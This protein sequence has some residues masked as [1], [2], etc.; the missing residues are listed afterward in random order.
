MLGALV[1]LIR[2]KRSLWFDFTCQWM[3]DQ[4]RLS[5]RMEAR[6]IAED[7]SQMIQSK[8][9]SLSEVL[10]IGWFAPAKVQR[11]YQW[12][13]SHIEKL[14]NDL[15]SAFQR[16]GS[17]PGEE[18]S[19]D[20]IVDGDVSTDV[21]DA[22]TPED[23]T[24]GQRI[25]IGRVSEPVRQIPDAY[26][27]GSLILFSLRSSRNF[28]VYDGLQRLTSI[29]ILLSLLRDTWAGITP[30]D[31]QTI[32]KLLF[33]PQKTDDNGR[34]LAFPTSGQ[35]LASVVSKRTLQNRDL[36]DG[37]YRM[38]DAVTFYSNQFDRRWND[39]RRRAFLAFLQDNV[40]LT[41]TETDNHSVAYQMF[42]AANT[43]GLRL[44]V[45]DVLKGM[46]ADQVR[47]SGGTDAQVDACSKGWRDGQQRLR[48]GFNDFVHAVEVFTFRPDSRPLSG[49]RRPEKQH[50]TGEKLQAFFDDTKS[51]ATICDWV[52]GGCAAMIRIFERGRAHNQAHH[53]DG[54]NISFRQLSF[55]GW[56]EW[57]PLLLAIGLKYTDF[58]APKFV[59]EVHSLKRACYLIELLDWSE[60]TRRR[61]IME[62]IEQLEAN[63]S[64]F[65]RNGK[66]K[67]SGSLY[68]HPGGPAHKAAKRA[69]RAA[70]TS[71]EKRGAI[72]R[73]IETLH[74]GETIPKSCTD[75][76]SVEHVLPIAAMGDWSKMFTD[77]E[78]EELTNRIGNLC[79]LDKEINYKIGNKEWSEKRL[80]YEKLRHMF[81]G[82]DYVLS[83][84]SA[85]LA[86]GEKTSVVRQSGGDANRAVSREG[87]N[88]LV[89]KMTRDAGQNLAI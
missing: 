20:Q 44:D 7:A 52:T 87:R 54:I 86:G 48:S 81:K 25:A 17:D 65:R 38:R 30:A 37:D 45:G 11:E 76:A 74:W 3:I 28:I 34:R 27:L 50:T 88:G 72:V 36:T 16:M 64:P 40:Q 67:P 26:F 82:A 56:T 71:E 9:V 66:D 51:P 69:L 70:L 13:T 62:S 29:N 46:F 15:V 77:K 4:R 83:T 79:I 43:R 22:D 1:H 63:L 23:T 61:K 12:Q 60:G 19:D 85:L 5:A 89:A 8:T 78:R 31:E 6:T 68:F 80:E 73:W 57:H 58:N 41:V 2:V 42:V 21:E 39:D 84:S 75:D 32:S 35:T 14:L 53:A 24:E 18:E 59:A 49:K 47:R 55:L 10:Q 33:D